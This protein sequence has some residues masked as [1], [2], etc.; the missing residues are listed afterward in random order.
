M[1]IA[2][3][4]ATMRKQRGSISRSPEGAAVVMGIV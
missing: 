3:K 1:K 2:G 4:R